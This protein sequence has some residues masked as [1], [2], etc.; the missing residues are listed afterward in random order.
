MV[1]ALVT[2][3]ENTNR[4]LNIV[5]ATYGLKDK[6]EAIKFVV[7]SFLEGEPALQPSFIK[8]MDRIR[9]E[10]SIRVDDFVK[11]YVRS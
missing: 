2:L 9:K 4:V 11:R 5:K 1:T 10:R 6:S 3:D 7:G 8:K